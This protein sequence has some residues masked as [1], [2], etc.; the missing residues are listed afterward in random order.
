MS[1]LNSAILFGLI[2][3]AI[4]IIIHLLTRQKAKTIFFSSLRFLKKLENQQIKRI[5]LKQILLLILRTLIILLLVLAFARPTLRGSFFAGIGSSA[6]T[7]A[8]I[9]LDN[10]LSLGLRTR[11]QQ[12]FDIA[13]KAVIQLDD[14]FSPGD[15]VFGIFGSSG[16]AEMFEGARYN[17]ESVRKV[18][19]KS[20]VSQQKTDLLSAMSKAENILKA[21]KN[22]NKEIYLFT[23]FQATAFADAANFDF[24]L[25]K[26]GQIKFYIFPITNENSSNLVI[27]KIEFANQIIEMGKIFEL[28]CV[29]KNT[30][31][32]FEKN[33]LVQVFIDGKRSGQTTVD[34]GPGETQMAKFKIVPS[35]TGRLSGSILLEDD[36][37]FLDNRRFFTFYV[38]E[39]INV[40]LVAQ[41]EADTRFLKMALNPTAEQRSRIK[42]DYLKPEQIQFG[43]LKDYSVVILSNVPQIDGTFLSALS[44]H[45]K[46]GKGILV[47]LG[48][49]VDLRN[50][51]ENLN[52]VLSLPLFTE[53]IGD[54]G[55]RKP[56]L[57]L[58]KID[59]SHPIFSGVFEKD[60]RQ[61]ESP[62][63]YFLT[64]IKT[65]PKD[66]TIIQFS[67]GD[68]FLVE[69]KLDQGKV[70]LFTSAIDPNW[71][72]LYLK[73]LFVPLL[74][75]SV[76]YLA[77]N[78]SNMA[79]EFYV[80]DELTA[81]L[82]KADN[83]TDFQ[84]KKPDGNISRIIPQIGSSSLKIGFKDTDEAG[85]YSLNNGEKI[86]AQWAVNTDPL[87]SEL[88]GMDMKK[89]NNLIG[90]YFLSSIDG[91]QNLT[92]K[93]K[94]ARYGRELWKYFIGLALVLLIAEMFI[95]KEPAHKSNS[96][97][98]KKIDSTA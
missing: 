52:R 27:A 4:P 15:E 31:R 97:G 74:N 91:G 89:F 87:E 14:V 95:A 7:S 5:R 2:A 39:Q 68:P 23:D 71:S 16:A 73:G 88:S 51:N 26:N 6:K 36:D 1:F 58:G 84:I 53:T 12:L 8:V 3:G 63:F 18:V 85:I 20:D 35:K 11:G 29:I 69:S 40:L 75:R 45:I 92:E 54:I 47:F 86:F 57:S 24:E 64:R 82:S 78:S 80:M 17:F 67:N 96:I 93:I 60:K 49:E 30:G 25:I 90:N 56:Y 77:S 43:T 72:D 34:I 38:P 81:N 42:I 65:N 70:L 98:V 79:K 22:A 9:I 37:L 13:K 50:Y 55:E 32:K 33:K 46:S 44:D 41:K 10:S 61:V 28:N 94:A 83:L 48:S 62:V 21:A 76:F 59:Y 19:Q 66:E